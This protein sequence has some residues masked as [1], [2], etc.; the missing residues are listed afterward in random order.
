[1]TAQASC[2]CY[3]KDGDSGNQN[4]DDP[5]EQLPAPRKGGR[6]RRAARVIPDPRARYIAANGSRWMVILECIKQH[7][8][9]R[10]Y[11]PY[12][13]TPDESEAM[14]LDNL[15]MQLDA[16]YRS[17]SSAKIEDTS[18]RSSPPIEG[19]NCTD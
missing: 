5:E 14:Q 9:S 17:V 6:Q 4:M 2:A 10:G 16:V 12:Q 7:L 1:M 15:F 13:P 8:Q 19:E 11:E 18:I 3:G